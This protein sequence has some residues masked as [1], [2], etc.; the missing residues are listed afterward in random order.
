MRFQI[1]PNRQLN[2]PLLWQALREHTLIGFNSTEYDMPMIQCALKG[3]T[4]EQLHSASLDI[5][6]GMK[7]REFAEKHDL[8]RHNFDHVDLIQVAPLKASPKIYA[9][10]LHCKKMQDLPIDPYAEVTA[11][12]AAL[13]V[14]YC[15][16]DLENTA[17]LFDELAAQI[18]LRSQLSKQ[19]NVDLR[20]RSDAQVAEHIIAAEIQKINGARPGRPQNL[21]GTSF[22]YKVP[23]FVSYRLPQLQSMLERVRAAE[24]V[25]S[26]TGHSTLPPELEAIIRIGGC[27]YRMGIGGLH[28]SE[29]CVAHLASDRTWLIDRDVTSYY[30]AIILNQGLYPQHLGEAFLQVYRSL[31]DR[32]IAAKKA[33]DKS[34]AESLKIAVNGSFGKLGNKWSVLYAPD[35][36]IQVTLTGQLSLLMLIEMIEASSVITVLSANTDGVL[37]KCQKSL[38]PVL[39]D[40][41][42]KWEAITGFTTEETRYDAVYSKD[43]NNYLAIKTDG[44]VKGKGLYANPWEKEGPNVYKLQKNPSTTIVIEAVVAR[45]RD[46]IPLEKTIGDCRDIR[47]FLSVRAVTG[48][49]TIGKEYLGRAVRWYYS[50]ERGSVLQYKKATKHGTHNKVPKTDGS[51]P[52]ME[53]P[54]E[55]PAD[56]NYDWYVAEAKSVLGNI[57]YAQQTL[58]PAA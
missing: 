53:L 34:T 31:V 29:T 54:D 48:G 28:S 24:F 57:G 44:G 37:I 2:K 38:Y 12:Q 25:V 5:I 15:G 45:L 4:A 41:I 1:S 6:G 8:S 27:S 35:L 51:K 40:I 42:A 9:G 14:E 13:L 17:V 36:M 32:R 52:L 55:F 22:R 3:Y 19:Y 21:E 49:A 16:N 46:G 56:V 18:T 43:V 23:D 10:R 11:E 39:T 30:P 50:R 26:A 20:S 47:K 33:G 58:F 7:P